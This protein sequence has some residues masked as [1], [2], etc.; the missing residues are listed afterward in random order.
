MSLPC[1]MP[2]ECSNLA[3]FEVS[4]ASFYR[5]L[6]KFIINNDYWSLLFSRFWLDSVKKD[7]WELW[8]ENFIINTYSCFSKSFAEHSRL[9]DEQSKLNKNFPLQKWLSFEK[10][11]L[12]EAM[13]IL[14]TDFAIQLSNFSSVEFLMR[15]LQYRSYMYHS[16]HLQDWRK[17]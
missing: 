1:A 11:M 10:S 9:I 4:L 15:V 16:S 2:S 5:A 3:F 12:M 6:E 14:Y 7:F 8:F 17:Q 13:E